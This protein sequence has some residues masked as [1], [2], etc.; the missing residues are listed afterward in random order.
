MKAHQPQVETVKHSYMC[1]DVSCV[2][3]GKKDEYVSVP[4]DSGNKGHLQKRL[5]L[6]N[7]REAY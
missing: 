2:M 4:L 6:C 3:P 7:S 5:M 1:D